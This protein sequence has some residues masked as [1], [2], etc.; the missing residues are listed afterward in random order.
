MQARANALRPENMLRFH[1]TQARKWQAATD[2]AFRAQRSPAGEQW[3]KLAA[4]TLA[5]RR[6]AAKG[7]QSRSAR[8]QFTGDQ[9][10]NR[11]GTMR[12]TTKYVAEAATIKLVT[13]GYM[14]PHQVGASNGRPPKRNPLVFERVGGK[15]VLAEPFGSEYRQAFIEHVEGGGA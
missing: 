1:E 14:P 15:P 2:A 7:G 3:P 13:V 6:R 5:A 12:A 10:L 4:S 9:A 8:G 11:T